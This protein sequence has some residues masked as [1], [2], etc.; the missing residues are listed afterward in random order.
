MIAVKPCIVV[1][2]TYPSSTHYDLVTLDVE[3]GKL[4]DQV[5]FVYQ[6]FFHFDGIGKKPCAEDHIDRTIV[7]LYHELINCCNFPFR[8]AMSEVTQVM[9]SLM[10]DDDDQI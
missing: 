9:M 7:L 4:T 6:A 1:V 2:I 8:P 5:C 10:N 3:H